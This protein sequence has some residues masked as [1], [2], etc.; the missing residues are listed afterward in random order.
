MNEKNRKGM[1]TQKAMRE[2]R[3]LLIT[4]CY[5]YPYPIK[6]KDSIPDPATFIWFVIV[7]QC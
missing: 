1:E 2:K 3:A 5:V 6:F 7:R 4:L